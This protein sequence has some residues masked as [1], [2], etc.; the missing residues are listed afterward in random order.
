MIDINKM[1]RLAQAAT[2][3]PWVAAGPSFG[4]SLPKY[5][6][7]VAVDREGDEDDGYSICN[8][9][10]GLN[11][12]CSDDMAFIAEANPLTIEELLDRLEAAEKSRDDLLAGLGEW[13]DKTKWVQQGV[14][15][16][17]I[18]AKYLGLHRADVMSSL[19]G[20]AEKARD[21]L[22]AEITA[23]ERQR[24]VRF[25]FKSDELDEQIKLATDPIW[26][27]AF[28]VP[29][30]MVPLYALPGAQPAPGAPWVSLAE[31]MPNPDKHDRV[32]I[33][34]EGYDFGGEQVF[35]VKAEALNECRYID[36][37][38]QPETCK[39]ASHWMPHP[40]NVIFDYAARYAQPAPS[41]PT[42]LLVAAADLVAQ[43]EIV[44]RVGFVDTPNDKD[45]CAAFCVA[46]GTWLELMSAVESLASALAA[47]PEAKP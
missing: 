46:E 40:R 11:E 7:E 16:G 30:G 39:A 35:D 42:A 45:S 17:T 3:G 26:A 2:P 43:M 15:E 36:P 1:R 8:A 18:S 24:P 10:I 6:N 34:T 32:L 37:D 4:E 38:E 19:L 31:R 13:L 44:S 9:P 5:L 21:A 22:R 20:E 23:M 28:D 41:V 29:E 25:V 14:N 12:E 33:Y 27:E 47:A